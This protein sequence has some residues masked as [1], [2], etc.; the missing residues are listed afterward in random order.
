MVAICKNIYVVYRTYSIHKFLP[1]GLFKYFCEGENGWRVSHL[2][3]DK[4]SIKN[5]I[6]LMNNQIID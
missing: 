4:K 1:L 3:F 5:T 6:L 2:S